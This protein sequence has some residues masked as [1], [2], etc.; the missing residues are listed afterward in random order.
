MSSIQDEIRIAIHAIWTRRW[1]ALGVAWAVC[2]AG[3]LFVSQ[4]PSR[5]ESRARIAVQNAQI[6]PDGIASTQA[7]QMDSVDQVRQTLISAI[8]LQKVVRGTDLAS[9]VSSDADVAARVSALAQSIKIENQQDTIFQLTVTQS[10]PK[11]AQQVAQKLIDIFV[12]SNLVGDRNN[13]NQ[14]LAFLDK[15][16]DDRQKQL[17]IAE[18]KRA[19]YQNQFLGGLPGS[20]SV[21]DRIG[22][23]RSQ[24][25]QVDSDM[26]AAQSSVAAVQGQL[27]GTPRTVG[28]GG[29]VAGPARARLAT[30][31]GQ[32]ADARARGYTDSH[33][34]VIA[35]KNQLAVAQAA[36]RAEPPGGG[37]GG[38]P[39]PLYMSLQSM[40]A[41]KQAQLA[42]LKM[43]KSQLQN[44]LD[45]LN[46]SLS[47]DPE[48]AAQQ[49]AIDRDYQV[50]KDSYDQLLRQREQVA[51]R[52]QAQNQTDSMRFSVIDPPTYPRTPTAPNRL[53][54]LT[55][56][57][58]AAL[59]LGIGTAFALSKLRQTFTTP[60]SL[61]RAMGLPVIGAIGEVVT[62]AQAEVRAKR[63][64]LFLGG[65]AALG[66]AYGMVVAIELLQRGM[67]A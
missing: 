18:A 14:S 42:S 27:A 58:L 3:W 67:A 36:A 4:I 38:Q 5:Y 30:L 48:A 31:Q 54:L 55:G 35:L 23:A 49:G 51:L 37:A 32:L 46:A 10:S 11:L 22:L 15:Q 7:S 63:M 28:E 13:T 21:A 57:F 52:G 34:D 39:N 62:R 64:K 66:A 17:Q 26:A 47:T 44:D 50:L 12:E 9:T 8:N 1:L 53:L 29:G 2:I 65:T 41:E 59:G 25:A 24:M 60:H 40:A 19:Q 56:V 45:R 20:G 16:L 33:P 43:R 61:Q 6:L